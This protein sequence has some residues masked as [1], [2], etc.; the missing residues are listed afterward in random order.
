MTYKFVRVRM[1]T[2]VWKKFKMHCIEMD[3][4]IPKQMTE[5]ARKFVE[6]QDQNKKL[7]GK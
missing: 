1:P 3:V 7:I 6:I 4:S 5:L 2:E